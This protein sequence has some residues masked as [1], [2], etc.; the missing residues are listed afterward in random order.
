MTVLVDV[1]TLCSIVKRVGITHFMAGMEKTMRRDFKRWREF[2][3]CARVASHSKLGVIELMPI[4][5]SCRYAFKYVNGHPANT[6]IGVPTVM[7]FGALAQ[8]DTG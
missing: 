4:S 2:D 1:A 7:A 3:K 6:K 8:V 5:D